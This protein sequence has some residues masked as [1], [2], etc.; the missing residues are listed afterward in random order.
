MRRQ[1]LI[2]LVKLFFLHMQQPHLIGYCGRE[3][4]VTLLGREI[5][6]LNPDYADAHLISL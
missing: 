4:L 3:W 2:Q 6:E 1:L 5:I